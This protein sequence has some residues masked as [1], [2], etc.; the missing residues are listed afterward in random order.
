MRPLLPMFI[1]S[2]SVTEGGQLNLNQNGVK[3]SEFLVTDLFYKFSLTYSTGGAAVGAAILASTLFNQ[4]WQGGGD[5]M[6]QSI[7]AD[8][9]DLWAR[10]KS[11]PGNTGY[12]VLTDQTPGSPG[13]VHYVF[14]V[15]FR[16]PLA[17]SGENDYVNPLSEVG[18]CQIQMP[19]SLTS[20]PLV[21]DSGTVEMFAVGYWARGDREWRV[22][23]RFCLQSYSNDG[24]N[25][26]NLSPVYGRL[27]SL[28][29]LAVPGASADLTSE[30]GA[31]LYLDREQITNTSVLNVGEFAYLLNM[32]DESGVE[33]YANFYPTG[34]EGASLVSEIYPG[35]RSQS[36]AHAPSPRLVGMQYSTRAA[37]AAADYRY[38]IETRLPLTGQNIIQ[39]SPNGGAIEAGDAAQLV[40]RVDKTGGALP[41]GSVNAGV[42]DF[43]PAKLAK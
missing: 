27:V 12:Y 21:Y 28:A 29:E 23:N 4:E 2:R 10:S 33:A 7:R 1:D 40:S 34:V 36:I 32:N 35:E 8:E 14:R 17:K 6:L 42:K 22:G 24:S 25:N 31:R 15:P 26:I 18:Q 43:L 38:W 20:G 19:A 16:R 30:V 11:R 37:T 13:T 39:R 9:L 3:Q 5:T 41:P